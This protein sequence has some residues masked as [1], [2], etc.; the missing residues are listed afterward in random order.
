MLP[1]VIVGLLV[2]EAQAPENAPRALLQAL[3][4]VEVS[5]GDAGRR[6][7]YYQ[8][9]QLTFAAERGRAAR[10]DFPLLTGP[11]LLPGKRV[12]ITV[13][14]QARPRV[15]LDGIITH[16][17][18]IAGNAPTLLVTGKDL[19]VLMDLEY[20]GKRRPGQGDKE[21]ALDILG[22]YASYGIKAD[23]SSPKTTSSATEDQRA[24]IQAATDREHVR[25]LASANGFIFCLKPGPAAKQSTAYWGP[26]EVT[27][28]EQRA[29]TTN[30]G[31]GT[32]VAELRFSYDGLAA[33]QVIGDYADPDAAEP[34]AVQALTRDADKSFAKTQE[35]SA[36]SAFLRKQRLADAPFGAA[37]SRALAQAAA[38]RSAEE[39]IVAEG[40]LDTAR[41]GD[42]LFAPGVVGVRGA[43]DTYD[44]DYYISRVTHQI[45]PKSYTQKFRLTREGPGTLTQKVKA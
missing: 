16:Q 39:V 28:R 17:Q 6:R 40:T 5:Q 44:G 43:G 33:T 30:A 38:N 45:T 22:K 1:A 36:G 26:P 42:I 18:L 23:A 12:V 4:R 35:L 8:G 24:P 29:L 41:Y 34:V 27:A 31:A 9:F 10:D 13:T 14:V 37:E 2:G 32:N 20:A 25:A 3:T 7:D 19:S 15:L 11:L 21:V